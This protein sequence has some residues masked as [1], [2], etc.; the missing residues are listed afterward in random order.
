MTSKKKRLNDTFNA[1]KHLN[2]NLAFLYSG[3]QQLLLKYQV[4]LI[5]L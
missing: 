3:I 1:N 4:E 5:R 2:N